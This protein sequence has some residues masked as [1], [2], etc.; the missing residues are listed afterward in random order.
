M[1]SKRVFVVEVLCQA[2]D[3]V[4]PLLEPPAALHII[5]N[6][7]DNIPSNARTCGAAFVVYASLSILV[8]PSVHTYADHHPPLKMLGPSSR[9][10]PSSPSPAPHHTEAAHQE[11]A[12]A[13]ASCSN[14]LKCW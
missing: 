8:P 2:F 3:S 7:R 9:N 12:A 11:A 5:R 6:Y 13:G 1:R 10:T 14:R 4:L